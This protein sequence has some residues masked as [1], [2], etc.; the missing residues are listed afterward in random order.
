MLP[1]GGGGSR[2][3]TVVETD[4]LIHHPIKSPP[5]GLSS[6]RDV[7]MEAFLKG[8]RPS[9]SDRGLAGFSSHKGETR[10]VVSRCLFVTSSNTLATS[11][12]MM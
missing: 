5:S 8:D 12:I 2:R 9:Y 7:G 4:H 10:C 11:R 1:G 3:L 6:L